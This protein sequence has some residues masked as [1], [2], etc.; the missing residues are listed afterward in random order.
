[1]LRIVRL[2][3][4]A[5]A[6]AIALVG[7]EAGN[8][9]PTLNWHS[10]TDG[11][12]ATVGGLSIRN[13]FIVGAP[14]DSSLTA[15]QSAG[16]FFAVV[17][18]GRPDRLLSISAPGTAASVSIPGGGVPLPRLSM[19]RFTGPAPRAVLVDLSR[20][21]PGGSFVTV[22]MSFRNAGRVTLHVPVMPRAQYFQTYLPPSPT[23]AKS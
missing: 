22:T 15:G 12:D 1:M 14:L 21:V 18:T 2:L 9:A 6:V 19:A 16:L 17:N 13:V 10:S 11:A 4:V 7:C 20:T 5:V 8:N 3:A 23:P